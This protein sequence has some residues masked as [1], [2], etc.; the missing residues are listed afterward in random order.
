LWLV[1]GILTTS[2]TKQRKFPKGLIFKRKTT[3][4][5][6]LIL[7]F[8]KIGCQRE[9]P[10]QNPVHCLSST[11]VLKTSTVLVKPVRMVTLHYRRVLPIN[12]LTFLYYRL[13]YRTTRLKPA[14]TRSNLSVVQPVVRQILLQAKLP[15]NPTPSFYRS[16]DR[17]THDPTIVPTVTSNVVER[18]VVRQIVSCVGR[19]SNKQSFQSTEMVPCRM[20]GGFIL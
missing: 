8:K 6:I 15:S 12:S 13:E 4:V 9:K 14:Y 3:Y 2:R 10:G 16:Y 20:E 11:E 17:P 19:L 5:L 1:V 18:S 7:Q